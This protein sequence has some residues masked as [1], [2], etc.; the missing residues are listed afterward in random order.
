VASL[1]AKMSTNQEAV[2]SLLT[3]VAAQRQFLSPTAKCSQQRASSRSPAHADNEVDGDNSNAE[4]KGAHFAAPSTEVAGDGIS[5]ITDK[6]DD[7]FLQGKDGDID[8]DSSGFGDPVL[9]LHHNDDS[10]FPST[11]MFGTMKRPR[12]ELEGDEDAVVQINTFNQDFS[13]LRSSMNRS[14][15]STIKLPWETGFFATV[16]KLGQNVKSA[17][18]WMEPNIQYIPPLPVESLPAAKKLFEVQVVRPLRRTARHRMVRVTAATTDD[19]LRARA[20]RVWKHIIEMDLRMTDVGC[21]IEALYE[22]NFSD[23]LVSTTLS[24][25]FRGKATGTLTKRSSAFLHFVGCMKKAKSYELLGFHEPTVYLYLCELRAL[26]SAPTKAHGFKQAMTFMHHVLGIPS[27]LPAI[28]SKRVAGCC[29]DQFLKKRK[30][31]QARKLKVIEVEAL[32]KATR[33]A[34]KL[35]DR[36]AAGHFCMCLYRCSRFYDSQH[37]ERVTCDIDSAGFGTIL[38]ES[39]KHKTSTS[40]DKKTKLLPMMALTLGVSDKPWGSAWMAAREEAG[41]GTHSDPMLPAVSAS[42]VFQARAT[43]TS[44]ATPWLRDILAEMGLDSEDVSTHGLKATILSWLSLYNVEESVRRVVGHHIDPA[45]R[46]CLTYSRDALSGPMEI[47]AKMLGDIR[48]GRFDPDSTR[49][50]KHL[51]KKNSEVRLNDR[52]AAGDDSD[53]GLSESSSDDTS[54]DVSLDDIIAVDAEDSILNSMRSSPSRPVSSGLGGTL[55]QH[56]HTGMIHS[57]DD[58]RPGKLLCGRS[59]SAVYS[60]ID[61]SSLK[62]SW[63]DCSSCLVKQTS[64][65]E[66]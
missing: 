41:L 42:E 39:S 35:N 17:A 32:E 38:M 56:S 6:G 30:L 28:K 21:Q 66:V 64:R 36:V 29:T 22:E 8:D 25:T 23:Q 11:H 40:Q 7:N 49:R 5:D 12:A 31:K 45:S 61:I 4:D 63:P 15:S 10:S 14:T 9:P 43:T 50:I 55:R 2:E 60:L 13:V 47:I 59:V 62:M 24:D 1:T 20:L 57:E 3:Q 19:E 34:H 58:L 54:S 48:S 18:S 44:E 52:E 27:A 51:L 26:L 65:L 16:V 53:V 37:P 46:S 33:E